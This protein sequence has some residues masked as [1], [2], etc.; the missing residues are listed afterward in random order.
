M[1]DNNTVETVDTNT[2][3]AKG[4]ETSNE[5]MMETGSSQNLGMVGILMLGLA[6][7]SLIYSIFYYRKRMQNLKKG[8]NQLVQELRKD[9]EE[10]KQKLGTLGGVNKTQYGRFA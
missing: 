3:L 4:G 1:E 5:S 10:I 2:E 7:A 9:V 6:S 8:E